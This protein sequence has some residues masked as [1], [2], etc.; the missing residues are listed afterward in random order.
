MKQ[1]LLLVALLIFNTQIKAQCSGLVTITDTKFKDALVAHGKTINGVGTSIID[2]N[3]DGEIQCSEANAYT[4]SI[5]V[6]NKGVADFTGL[7]QFTEITRL[8][9][10]YNSLNTIDISANTKLTLVNLK[11]NNLTGIDL[12]KN[13]LLETLVADENQL[14]NLDVTKNTALK[15]LSLRLNSISSIDLTKN[16]ALETLEISNNTIST[17]DI[18][19][20]TNLKRFNARSNSLSSLDITKNTLLEILD[21]QK[22]SF[23]NLDFSQ[24]QNLTQ[25]NFRKN[26]FISVDASNNPNLIE[27]ICDNNSDLES[28]NVANGNNGALGNM[29]ANRNPKL[30][31]IQHDSGFVPPTAYSQWIKDETASWSDNCSG[32]ASIQQNEKVNIAIYP[33]PVKNNISITLDDTIKRGEIYDCLG[34]KIKDIKAD[35]IDVSKLK[36]GIYLLK[37]ETNNGKIGF[38]KF[39][40]E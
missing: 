33:N 6:I 37:I 31:C 30:T 22:N 40:K 2:T 12:S 29:W 21:V 32:T 19:A 8:Y 36:A 35:I 24:N 10:G 38:K 25:I 27:F 5:I 18:T 13:T 20:N 11:G 1:V 16:T 7:E 23:T 14:N 3:D 9:V 26:N 4:G 39:V 17:L 15:L 28:L 34:K